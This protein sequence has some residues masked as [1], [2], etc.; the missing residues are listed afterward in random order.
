MRRRTPP[1]SMTGPSNTVDIHPHVISPDI[2]RYPR[3]IMGGKSS[4]WGLERPVTCEE[5][6]AAMDL[7][8][9]ERAVVVHASSMYG[10]DNSYVAD[11]VGAYSD[12]LAA[13][14]SIDLRDERSVELSTYWVRERGLV[15]LRVFAAGS[16]SPGDTSAWIADPKTFP[17]WERVAELGVPLC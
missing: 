3:T 7:A 12:R 1:K 5:L 6:L 17:V 9:I 14:G 2:Q 15:G 16:G 4:A 8:K 13:V 11:C 10:M